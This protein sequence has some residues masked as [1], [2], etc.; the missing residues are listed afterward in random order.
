MNKNRSTISVSMTIILLINI[1]FITSVYGGINEGNNTDKYVD[2]TVEEAWELLND[3]SN[4]I[5]YPIDVRTDSEWISAHIDAPFPEYARHHN[6]YEWDD[7]EILNEFLTTYQGKEI[8]VYCQSG[9]RSV[10]ASNILID[11]DFDGV[12]YN[13][14][15]GIT[16]WISSGYPTNP[17]RQPEKPFISGPSSGIPG[18]ESEFIIKTDDPDYD[19]V[20]FMINWSDGYDETLIGPYDSSEDAQIGHTWTKNGIYLI[21]VKAIDTYGKESEW[22]TFEFSLSKTELEIID[23]KGGFGSVIIDI[24][25]T[26]TH[27]AEGIS[28]VIS[29][30]GG[31]F[32]GINL[33]HSCSGCDICGTTLDPGA[34]KTEN[35]K[36]SG[37]I[38]GVGNI[39]VSVSA[40]ANNAEKINKKT[41][42]FVFGPLIVIL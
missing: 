10:S 17:N 9:G 31:F 19:K 34:I 6:F 30:H 33:T 28:S 15:G 41:N 24:K 27:I 2:I 14:L 42:G 11:N 35:T 38:L 21:K 13:M 4:G 7:P 36:E 37:F 32:S 1:F 25:N 20:Y 22:A 26:G 3:T 29:V 12:I 40:W 5:Q 18:E 16:Q 39:E 8:I 23:I